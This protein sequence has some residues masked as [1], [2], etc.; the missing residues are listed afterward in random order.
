MLLE[1][2]RT[3]IF[4]GDNWDVYL[5][6]FSSG[7]I[8]LFAFFMITDPMTTPKSLKGRL[9]WGACIGGLTFYLTNY[10]QA[11]DA[12]IWALTIATPITIILNLI[13][14]GE[15]FEWLPQNLSVSK[16]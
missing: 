9:I 2:G 11:Y 15:Q 4:F 14:K 5:Q 8:L 6:K 16:S 3:I 13:F 7:T 1:L 12:P 10:M